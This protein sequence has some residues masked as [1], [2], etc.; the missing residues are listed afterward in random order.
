MGNESTALFAQAIK[1][2][3]KWYSDTKMVLTG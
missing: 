3:C 2:L 1:F